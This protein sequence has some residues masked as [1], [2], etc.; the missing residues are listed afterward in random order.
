MMSKERDLLRETLRVLTSSKVWDG[1]EY[2]YLPIPHCLYKRVAD[3]IQELLSKP[4][5]TEPVA[6][7]A[8]NSIG[9]DVSHSPQGMPLIW[10]GKL[11][12]GN[13]LYKVS[14]KNE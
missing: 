1:Q 5:Q 4:E 11:E 12:Y 7:V 13:K 2:T 9:F 6:Y 10:L 3:E 8:E 14:A